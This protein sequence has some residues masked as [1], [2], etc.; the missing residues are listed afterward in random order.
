MNDLA[1]RA[2]RDHYAHVVAFLRRRTRSSDDAEEL[3]Q[4]VFAQAAESL[5]PNGR[6]PVP[7]WLY[8]VARRRLV[9]EARR[10]SRLG[11]AVSLDALPL[12]A[13]ERQYGGEGAGALRPGQGR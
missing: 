9:D 6:A 11:G 3:A 12:A 2:F 7:A 13:S 1:E 5:T 8:T 4:T 10:R